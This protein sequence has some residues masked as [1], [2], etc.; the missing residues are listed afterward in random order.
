MFFIF[1]SHFGRLVFGIYYIFSILNYPLGSFTLKLFH[2]FEFYFLHPQTH[3]VA[4]VV[5][6]AQSDSL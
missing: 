3:T 5:F 4:K 1:N 6:N 2:D